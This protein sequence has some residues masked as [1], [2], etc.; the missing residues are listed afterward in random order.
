[1]RIF[2]IASHN[3]YDASILT[4]NI[5]AGHQWFTKVQKAIFKSYASLASA[6]SPNL[7]DKI[8]RQIK[9]DQQLRNHEIDTKF[10]DIIDYL[11][12]MYHKEQVAAPRRSQLNKTGGHLP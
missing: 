2:N 5:Q 12:P 11:D 7:K 8:Y 9:S 10:A 6:I 1:M 3:L 4:R